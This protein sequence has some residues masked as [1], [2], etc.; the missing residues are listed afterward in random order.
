MLFLALLA[1]QP[2]DVHANYIDLAKQ[3]CAREW[4]GDFRMQN[5]CMNRDIEGMLRFKAASDSV[6]EA[7]E[8]ALEKCTEDWTDAGIPDWRMIGYCATQQAKAYRALT[9]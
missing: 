4:P 9:R 7:L 3:H 6:G 5:Y 1:A 2:F 8:P